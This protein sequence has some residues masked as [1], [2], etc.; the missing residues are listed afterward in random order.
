M[1]DKFHTPIFI[2]GIQ[3]SGTSLIARITNYSGAFAGH[4]SSMYEN[5]YVKDLIDFYYSQ[6]KV[7]ASGQYPLLDTTELLIPVVWQSKVQEILKYEKYDSSRPW[8]LKGFRLSQMWPVWH[9]AFPNAKW[10]IV[11]RRTGDIVN[12]CMKTDYMDAFKD[13]NNQSLIGVSNESEGWKWWIHYHEKL[14]VEMIENG[15]NCKVVWPDRMVNGDYSQIIET[16]D[17]L[18]LHW[19]SS[20]INII[21]PLLWHSKLKKGG[22]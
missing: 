10:I 20:I 8:M 6:L 3:R 5:V 15:L 12:S 11:R 16:L 22:E 13:K 7:P 4:V 1:N 14:F 2:T 19:D 21:D 17:W 18:G 9:Y